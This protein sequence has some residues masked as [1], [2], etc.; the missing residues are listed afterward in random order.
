MYTWW[1]FILNDVSYILQALMSKPIM[2]RSAKARRFASATRLGWLADPM[3][4]SVGRDFPTGIWD[5]DG[6][7]SLAHAIPCLRNYMQLLN[8]NCVQE[9][10][11]EHCVA[12]IWTGNQSMLHCYIFGKTE[13][14]PGHVLAGKPT[15][16]AFQATL[17]VPYQR[18]GRLWDS[19]SAVPKLLWYS[20]C[21]CEMLVG[22]LMGSW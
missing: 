16:A 4:Q 5:T 8:K 14:L 9:T 1:V 13:R 6:H 11:T 22:L 21:V 2:S 3:T 18:P 12:F 7:W 19:T 10:A 17:W 15:S 20:L